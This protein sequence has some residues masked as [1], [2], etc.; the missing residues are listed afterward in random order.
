MVHTSQPRIDGMPYVPGV[1]T[2]LLQKGPVTN[3]A[4]TVLVITPEDIGAVAAS[5]AGLI[6]VDAAPFSHTLIALLGRGIPTVLVNA[7]QAGRLEPG[8]PIHIDGATGTLC[9]PADAGA[10][11]AAPAIPTDVPRTADGTPVALLASVRGP[12]AAGRAR[13]LGAKAIGLVR[14]EFLQPP[15]GDMP[16]RD[17]YRCRFQALIEAAR[18]LSITIRLLDIAADKHPAWLAQDEM[19]GQPLGL[20]GVRLFDR[21]PVE[22][23]VEAQVA[24]V[25]DLARD[26]DLRVLL[27]FVTRTEE[28]DYWRGR[29]DSRLPG[30]MPVGVMAETVAS[31]L[32]IDRL[33]DIADFVAIGC[34]DLMQAV[35]SADRDQ[36]VLRDYLDP[37]APVLLRLMR[38]IAGQAGD[39]LDRVQL[40][41]LLPQIRGILPPLVGMGYRH[42]SVDGPFIPYLAATL[43]EVTQAECEALATAVCAARSTREVLEILHLPGERPPPYLR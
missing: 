27:P 33:L 29:L 18:P 30:H 24:A 31:V 40:C 2:G 7:A 42:F 1:A 39:R 6:V 9:D 22:G 35:F 11:H 12:A 37:Y 14:S 21:P 8:S 28:F 26:A 23:I 41:G 3:S 16:D 38:Q 15:T 25:A 43:A 10:G 19:M 32:D 4:S 36:P 13:E 34:N 5:A 20:Q 17:F